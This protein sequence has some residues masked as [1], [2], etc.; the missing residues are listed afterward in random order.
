[1]TAIGLQLSQSAGFFGL[2]V[3]GMTITNMQMTYWGSTTIENFDRKTKR[4][5][6]ARLDPNQEAETSRRTTTLN[7]RTTTRAPQTRPFWQKD[8]G[9]IDEDSGFQRRLLLPLPSPRRMASPARAPISPA[10]SPVISPISP[11]L[12]ALQ[13]TLPAAS[14]EGQETPFAVPRRYYKLY[15]TP[16]GLHPWR[17]GFKR[18]FKQIMGPRFWD[19][20]LPLHRPYHRPRSRDSNGELEE[21]VWSGKELSKQMANDGWARGERGAAMAREG[22]IH[23]WYE[24]SDEF[25]QFLDSCDEEQQSPK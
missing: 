12:P 11:V 13:P 9:T 5:F 14:K 15:L 6:V 7:P 4:Y 10:I 20:L 17:I 24:F 3:I 8:D 22:G 25:I 2:F 1:M 19:W 21:G 23:S 18:N 16:I